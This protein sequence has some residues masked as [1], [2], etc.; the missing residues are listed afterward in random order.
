VAKRRLLPGLLHGSSP[1]AAALP[2]AMAALGEAAV[3]PEVCLKMSASYTIM[4]TYGA[5]KDLSLPVRS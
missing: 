3:L 4:T 2:L 1:N 5:T